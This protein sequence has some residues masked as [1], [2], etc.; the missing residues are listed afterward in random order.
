MESM[1][2]VEVF[3]RP[4]LMRVRQALAQAMLC[5]LA[6]AAF[7]PSQN[8]GAHTAFFPTSSTSIPASSSGHEEG[9]DETSC[10]QFVALAANRYRQAV[11]EAL[12]R[13]ERDELR[14]VPACSANTART[15][16]LAIVRF[17]CED[18]NGLRQ[19]LI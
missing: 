16:A 1:M 19:L 3:L 4:R 8:D 5:A 10:L 7:I 6:F 18:P 13:E 14:S 15:S 2:R 11:P 17:S 9:G 12:R